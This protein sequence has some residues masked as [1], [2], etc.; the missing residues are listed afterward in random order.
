[1]NRV[2]SPCLSGQEHPCDTAHGFPLTDPFTG[3]LDDPFAPRDRF[4]CEHTKPFDAR[5]PNEEF[6]KGK[7]QVHTR[8]VMLL[9][10]N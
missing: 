1:V 3:V 5:T 6:K 4:F 8:N 2:N 9:R 10:H 7:L